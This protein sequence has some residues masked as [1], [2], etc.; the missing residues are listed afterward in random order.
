MIIYQPPQ[1]CRNMT[2]FSNEF[3]KLYTTI[4]SFGKNI[5]IAGDFNIHI[6]DKNDLD[7]EQFRD[8]LEVMGLDQHVHFPTYVSGHT[9]DLILSKMDQV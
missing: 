5:I 3:L 7:S 2:A 6:D 8:L 1:N 4:T 9:L